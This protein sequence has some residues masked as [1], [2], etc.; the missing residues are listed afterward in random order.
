MTHVLRRPGLAFFLAIATIGS[1]RGDSPVAADWVLQNGL[2][3]DGTGE[4]GRLG[5]VAILGDRIVAVGAFT[6]APTARVI[7]ATGLVIAPGFIDLHTHSDDGMVKPKLRH[8]V[9]YL[10]Q[11]VTTI[12]T[13]NCGSGPI[14]V[15][16]YFKAIEAGG[17]GS[18]VIHLIPH[19]SLRRSVM[20][21]GESKPS[22]R[23]ME[24][25]KS[26]VVR[27]MDAGAWGDVHG[28][29]LPARALC[30]SRRVGRTLADRRGE[31]GDLRQPYPQ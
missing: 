30:G 5:D 6:A 23:Q 21:N 22:A 28:P 7:D 10:T 17:A 19:G 15:E 25:M 27:G 11:G 4:P 9:N 13:G 8:N 14:D 12:V 16:A 31:G 1:A 20:G 18:N 29:D 3:V 24:G 26:R 2:I